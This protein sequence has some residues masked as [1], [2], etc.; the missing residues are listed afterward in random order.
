MATTAVSSEAPGPA[1]ISSAMRLRKFRVWSGV[2]TTLPPTP[3]SETSVIPNFHLPLF[4]RTTTGLID[5]VPDVHAS[6]FRLE[7]PSSRA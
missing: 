1:A 6:P 5:R 2:V 3:S 4:F 7:S